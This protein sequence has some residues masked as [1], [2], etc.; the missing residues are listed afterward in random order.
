MLYLG[1]D[2]NSFDMDEL[3][4]AENLLKEIRPYINNF[5]NSQYIDNLA[6]GS[7]CAVLGYS[8]DIIQ[9]QKRAQISDSGLEIKYILPK[10]GTDITIEVMAILADS[11]NK[12]NAYRFIDF[13][14]NPVNIGE[15]AGYTNFASPN[16][17]SF[18]YLD[19]KLISNKNIY[20]DEHALAKLYLQKLAKMSYIKSR[21]RTWIRILSHEQN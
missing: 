15:I 5:N 13:L 2:P 17:E 6:S 18:K 10:E 4:K 11:K 3:K 19:K 12:E 20:P 21:N 8:G 9:A 7:V 1:Y 16:L 14:L